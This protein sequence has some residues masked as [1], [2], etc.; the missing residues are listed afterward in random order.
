MRIPAVAVGGTQSAATIAVYANGTFGEAVAAFLALQGN[1]VAVLGVEQ[2]HA[3]QCEMYTQTRARYSSTVL[4]EA[5]RNMAAAAACDTVVIAVPA[6]TYSAAFED[7]SMHLKS[8]QTIFI[9]GAAIGA[10]LEAAHLL[11]SRRRDL[12]VR[13]IEVSLPFITSYTDGHSLVIKGARDSLLVAGCSLNETRVGLSIGNG[14]FNSL[15]PASNILE[16]AFFDIDRWL[17]TGALLFEVLNSRPGRPVSSVLCNLRSELI[18]LAKAY[19]INRITEP[20]LPLNGTEAGSDAQ[21]RLSDR[22]V[23]EYIILSSLA[24]LRYLPVPALDSVIELAS[25]IVGCD[26]RKEGRQLSD[27]GLIGMD[28]DEILEHVSA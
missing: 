20:P 21:Q 3:L 23:E 16:R 1:R 14:I 9:V 18:S 13:I 17:D 26:L 28:A 10:S 4:I 2:S 5:A 24:R 19:G 27:L 6:T 11:S 22:I 12:S 25:A 15:V 8:G 7:L